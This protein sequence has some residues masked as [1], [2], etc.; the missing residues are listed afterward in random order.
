MLD[1]LASHCRLG[2]ARDKD[3]GGWHA[4]LHFNQ[5]MLLQLAKGKDE[6]TF[7]HSSSMKCVIFLSSS[8]VRNNVWF[9]LL[10]SMM[11]FQL[12]EEVLDTADAEI[13]CIQFLDTADLTVYRV[14]WALFQSSPCFSPLS[15]LWQTY[16]G[17]WGRSALSPPQTT[18]CQPKGATGL[19]GKCWLGVVS[20]CVERRP[21]FCDKIITPP[22]N[23]VEKVT[24]SVSL[25]IHLPT[26][27]KLFA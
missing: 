18:R 1:L 9:K 2:T 27:I 19:Q 3:N 5:K 24:F 22:A 4:Q 21:V 11:S 15:D 17:R 25:S 20:H 26:Q 8:S 14:Q 6:L 13:G 7:F 16:A 10:S 12:D 23:K